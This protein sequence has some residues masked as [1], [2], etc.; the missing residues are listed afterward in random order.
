LE[1]RALVWFK[2]F[3]TGR[4]SKVR[5]G[6]T[7]SNSQIIV[8]SGVPQGTVSGTLLFLLYV[9]DVYASLPPG[10]DHTSFADDLKGYSDDPDKLQNA[11][12]SIFSWSQAWDLPISKAKSAVLHLG[13]R[14]P[15][16]VY[17]ID[18]TDIP[19]V[20]EIRDLGLIIDDKLRYESHINSKVSA[21]NVLCKS[22]IR[23]FRFNEPLKYLELYSMYARPILEYCSELYSPATNSCSSDTLEQPLRSF[24]RA[25]F[26][27]CN[28]PMINYKERLK[29]LE[30]PSQLDRRIQADLC[31]AYK[32]LFSLC[33]CPD[34]PFVLSR[35]PRHPLR[36]NYQSNVYYSHNFYFNR[37]QSL[38]NQISPLF[39]SADM[40][41]DCFKNIIVNHNF[42]ITM[43]SALR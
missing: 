22:I 17:T 11:I 28:L 21:V 8:T 30:F 7:L 10:V 40:S 27:R 24:T 39:I 20:H 33:Y 38:W 25:V 13:K 32:I 15:R 2:S 19:A 14:N 6:S 5:I 4:T 1:R 18:G 16:R 29:I 34:H 9:N 42:N 23:S 35:S 31:L 37:I 12:D 3:L 36:L 43:P 26:K 41:F